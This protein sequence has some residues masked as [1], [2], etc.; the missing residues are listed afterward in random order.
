LWNVSTEF[1]SQFFL[2]DRIPVAIVLGISKLA[3]AKRLKISR[4]S[5]R[6]FLGT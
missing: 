3:I 2:K 4:T 1:I 6:R 5:V